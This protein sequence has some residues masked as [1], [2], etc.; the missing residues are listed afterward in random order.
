MPN[1]KQTEE[2]E[3]FRIEINR[4]HD[5]RF[6]KNDFN[7]G[8]G[9]T[10]QVFAP[11]SNALAF[12]IVI[13]S[14]NGDRED[15]NAQQACKLGRGIV[16]QRIREQKFHKMENYCY[17]WEPNFMPITEVDCQMIDSTQ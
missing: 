3:G 4:I 6:I 17:R 5:E 10:F 9:W 8:F 2:F 16:H 13:K 15:T 1:D 7:K 14:L 12:S 11:E